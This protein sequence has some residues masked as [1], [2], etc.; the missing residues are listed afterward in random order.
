MF[1]G[2]LLHRNMGCHWRSK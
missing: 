2:W 1:H